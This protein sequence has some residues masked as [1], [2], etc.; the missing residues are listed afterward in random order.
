MIVSCLIGTQAPGDCWERQLLAQPEDGLV[1]GAQEPVVLS[2]GEPIFSG[3]ALDVSLTAQAALVWDEQT[4]T[5]LYERNVDARRPVASLSKLLAALKI[6]EALGEEAVVEIPTTVR[7]IQRQGAHIALPVGEHA[8]VA[9]LLGAGLVASANDAMVTLAYAVAGDEEK[10]A[11]MANDY[12]RRH[13]FT[14]TRVSN[15]TGLDGGEQYSTAANIKGLF[16]LAYRDKTLRNLLVSER[17]ALQTVEGSVRS[18]ESTNQLLGTYF[19]VLA[20]KTGYTPAAGQN[21]VVMTQ[22][23]DGQ[24]IGAVVLGS[25][26]RFQD[27]KILVEWVKRNYTWP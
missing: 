15:A 4:D 16:Q 9:D 17:S 5:I 8:L 23:E 24:R 19:S 20:A 12:A 14:D 2:N 25:A 1:A 3:Q 13:G 21:L 11:E 18:Y 10:F 22:G 27:M 6:R 26:D 7:D